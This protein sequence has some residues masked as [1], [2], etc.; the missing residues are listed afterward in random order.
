MA[1]LFY[2]DN[3]DGTGG[4]FTING[5]AP[6]DVHEIHASMYA[7]GSM[8]PPFV[9]VANSVGDGV[10]PVPIAPGP[11]H[12][13]ILT[14]NGAAVS[15]SAPIGFRSGSGELALHERCAL[16]IRDYVLALNIPGLP[17][18]PAH[19]VVTKVGAKLEQVIAGN[20]DG[21][22]MYYI[23]VGEDYRTFDNQFDTVQLPVVIALL[24]ESGQTL[25]RGLSEILL[26]RE[27]LHRNMSTCDLLPEIHTV[28][29]RPGA[30]IDPSRWL[31]NYDS[32]VTTLVCH[33][34]QRSGIV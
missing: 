28:Q 10:L 29:M 2:T 31:N 21:V 26:Y 3:N 12:A 16:A 9:I 34:E 6:G 13:L 18:N 19:H 23:P 8:N 33:T 17:I 1:N 30:V 25:A 15:L 20:V 7:G 4:V 11:Y 22:A 24:R 14:Q 27:L 32:S 5:S